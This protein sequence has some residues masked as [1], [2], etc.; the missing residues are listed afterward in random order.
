MDAIEKDVREESF[1]INKHLIDQVWEDEKKG[2]RKE[3][4]HFRYA[5][6]IKA[7]ELSKCFIDI[8]DI[9]NLN[10]HTSNYLKEQNEICIEIGHAITPVDCYVEE[11][12]K[13]MLINETSKCYIK[14]KSSEDICFTIRLK[15]IEIGK[16]YHEL[17]PSQ[18]F[19]QA[20]L[21]KENG[22]KM[23]KE[24]HLFAHNYFN[25]AAK[26]LLSFNT[27]NVEYDEL[28][29]GSSLTKSDFDELLLNIYLNIGACLIKQERYD[30]IPPILE[31]V[32][33]QEKPSEKG[34]Y[35]LATAY[36]H[37]RNYEEAEK[38]IKKINFKGNKDLV[39]LLGKIQDCRKT[40]ND[41]LSVMAKKML[42][43]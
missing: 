21:Y 22:V 8:F 13:E 26:C 34:V 3:V 5:S 16:Y 33:F 19:E 18:M 38:L 15:E 37:T 20:K 30:Q 31:F 39:V 41:R 4:V 32:K 29:K 2:L 17:N 6:I 40:E 43:G 12:L 25:L 14:T 35:R 42:F 36:F 9:H 7:N 1:D 24:Y 11:F 28:L 10:N 27:Q 23:F